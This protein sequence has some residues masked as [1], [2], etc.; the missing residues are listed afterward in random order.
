MAKLIVVR[1]R[2]TSF[3]G[4][5][6]CH[7]FLDRRRAAS[8]A[9]GTKVEIPLSPGR[10]E[11]SARKDLNRSPVVP[12]ECDP[13]SRREFR[14]VFRPFV[15]MSFA[16]QLSLFLGL[17]SPY[18]LWLYFH[19]LLFPGPQQFW[20]DRF[21]T[22]LILLLSNGMAFG[23]SIANQYGRLSLEPGLD[24]AAGQ[25]LIDET[26]SPRGRLTLRAMMIAVAVLAV[27]LGL[28]VRQWRSALNGFYRSEAYRHHSYEESDREAAE[29]HRASNNPATAA[30]FAARADYHA[31]MVRKYREAAARGLTSVEPDPPPPP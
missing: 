29:F 15:P 4:L 9:E 11:L 26:T 17:M 18:F 8:L 16:R 30:M 13:E 28:G 20:V 24:P 31:A 22:P 1:P 21:V 14:I 5:T 25:A 7:I 23:L 6:P 3:V 10:H 2:G 12:F 19:P 27:L